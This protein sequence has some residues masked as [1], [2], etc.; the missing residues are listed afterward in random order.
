MFE[1]VREKVLGIVENMSYLEHNGE[2]LYVFGKGGGARTA[3]KMN[4][5][6]LREIPLDPATR[7]GGDSGKPI[8]TVGTGNAQAKRFEELALKIMNWLRIARSKSNAQPLPLPTDVIVIQAF[9][10]FEELAALLFPHA[11]E[12]DDGAHDAAHLL[13]VWKNASAIQAIEGGDAEI[14]R[15][16]RCAARLCRRREGF[17]AACAGLLARRRESFALWSKSRLADGRI[18]AVAHAIESHS[19]SGGIKPESLEA[20]ILQDADR[21][22]SIGFVGVARCFYTAGRMGSALYN[23]DE[24]HALDDKR[25]A[26]DHFY[27]KL[28]KFAGSFQTATGHR[29]AEERDARITS[30]SGL[31]KSCLRATRLEY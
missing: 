16:R 28:L 11:V 12:H 14:H 30:V 18:S 24:Y 5:P 13:R 29:M 1:Q 15:R 3:E 31:L 20:K 7:E 10:P 4:V 8:A 22:D 26:L 19:F 9:Q 25:Y 2:K 17:A 21:L 6:L 27:T 23:P